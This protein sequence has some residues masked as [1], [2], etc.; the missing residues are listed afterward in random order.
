MVARRL[1]TGEKPTLS[2]LN[3]EE[4]DKKGKECVNFRKGESSMVT[5]LLTFSANKQPSST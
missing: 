2:R 5:Q 3:N 1:C 4:K